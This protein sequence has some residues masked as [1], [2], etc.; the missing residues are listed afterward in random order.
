MIVTLGGA[1]IPCKCGD[2]DRA[3]PDDE[4]TMIWFGYDGGAV[5][6]CRPCA[7]ALSLTLRAPLG[8]GR[9]PR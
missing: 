2:C 9:E 6:L 7:K 4:S 3:V 5:R 8:E 1:A